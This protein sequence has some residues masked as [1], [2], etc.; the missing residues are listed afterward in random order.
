MKKQD[1]LL[2]NNAMNMIRIRNHSMDIKSETEPVQSLNSEGLIIDVSPAWLIMT[3]YERDEVIGRFFGDFLEDESIEKVKSE[4]PHLK[5][6]GFVDNVRF[7]LRRKDGVVIEIALNGTSKY[8]DDGTFER[9]YCELRTLDYYMRSFDRINQILVQ[10]KFYKM[11]MYLKANISL[12]YLSDSD[13]Y[14]DVLNNILNEPPEIIQAVIEPHPKDFMYHDEDSKHLINIA[15]EHTKKHPFTNNNRVSVVNDITQPVS[16]AYDN[17]YC[18]IVQIHDDTMPNHQRL[19][20]ISFNSEEALLKEWELAFTGISKIIDSVFRS[21]RIQQENKKLIEELKRLSERDNLTN[22]FNRRML[23]KILSEQMD[24]VDNKYFSL[25]MVDIDHFKN[26]NDT[27]GHNAGDKVLC[28]IS[29]LIKQNIRKTDVIGRWGG[30]EFL[31]IC[32][33]TRLK[34]AVQLA[35]SLRKLVEDYPFPEVGHL[36]ASFGVSEFI[37]GKTAEQLIGKADTALYK[38]KLSGRNSVCE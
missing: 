28:E 9:T 21:I 32:P 11:I 27:F 8:Y 6:Y 23:N 12:L 20:I 36:T 24:L 30:E 4:F 35:Q 7:K 15:K 5:D 17:H 31:I 34:N 22:I 37:E 18:I 3:G 13:I 38:A 14:Y 19:L 29:Q 26:V 16:L 2:M 33:Q 10:E 25:I 1:E